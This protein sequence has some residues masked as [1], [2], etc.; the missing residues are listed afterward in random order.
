MS[1]MPFCSLFFMSEKF[2][3]FRA[4]QV[5]N[6]KSW[7]NWHSRVNNFFLLGFDK[8][9]PIGGQPATDISPGWN[10]S[11][12]RIAVR[13]QWVRRCHAGFLLPICG[14]DSFRHVRNVWKENPVDRR[15][16]DAPR[17]EFVH[18]SAVD[19][20]STSVHSCRILNYSSL[21]CNIF[22]AF[23]SK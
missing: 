2:W 3:P 18:S 6:K 23:L 5:A 16:S 19:S 14:T 17:Y 21:I 20:H 8:D 10:S 12:R 4:A 13:A 22:A 9:R 7:S 15:A 11:P 1:F